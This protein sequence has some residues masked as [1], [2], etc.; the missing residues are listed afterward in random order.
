MEAARSVIF[1][2]YLTK[3]SKDWESKVGKGTSVNWPAGLGGKGNEGVSGLVKQTPGSIGYVELAYAVKNNLPY[4]ALKNKAGV[5]VEASLE[6]VTAAAAGSVKSMPDRSEG[7]DH[8]A[9]GK[10]SYPISG[11]TWLLIYKQMKDER[12]ARPWSNSS[13]GQ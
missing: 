5:F 3:V 8:D 10:A 9:D 12:K 7:F 13:I 6:S 2:D 11:F 1:T 4:A